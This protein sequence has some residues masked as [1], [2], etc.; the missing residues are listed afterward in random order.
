MGEEAILPLRVFRSRVF[1]ITSITQL[2]VGAAMFGGLVVAA[3]L[4]ADRARR[5]ARPRAGLML[6]PLMVGI[7]VTSAISGRIMSRTGRYKGFPIV[8]T[9][10]MF[11][12]L[13]LMSTLACDTADLAAEVYHGGH[14]RRARACRCRRSSSASRTPCR[15]GTWASRPA[16]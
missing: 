9:A 10:L 15:R 16:R 11:V 12:A 14:G 3:A 1:T 2:L 6:M 4:P 13:L 8:G 7:I 5:V